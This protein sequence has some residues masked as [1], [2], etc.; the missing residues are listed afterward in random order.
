IDGD[1]TTPWVTKIID[2]NQWIQLN[3]NDSYKIQRI[4]I[5]HRCR[6]GTQCD[7][8]TLRFSSGHDIHLNRECNYYPDNNCTHLPVEMYYI[9]MIISST[10]RIVCTRRCIMNDKRIGFDEILIWE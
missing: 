10:V 1:L 2:N 5:Y 4:D 9:N 7:N 8:L 3:F 6:Y